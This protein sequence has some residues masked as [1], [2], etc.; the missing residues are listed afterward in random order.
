MMTIRFVCIIL[1]IISESCQQETCSKD[2][3]DCTENNKDKFQESM[4]LR[5]YFP[6]LQDI[7][8]GEY[9]FPADFFT[10]YCE[11][12]D[13]KRGDVGLSYNYMAGDKFVKRL[14]SGNTAKELNKL[15][16]CV[17]DKQVRG[18]F[19][20]GISNMPD[21]SEP[22]E[23]MTEKEAQKRICS[24]LSSSLTKLLKILQPTCDQKGFHTMVKLVTD[25][26]KNPE[27]HDI[28]LLNIPGTCI[29]GLQK[30]LNKQ[31]ND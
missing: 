8:N 27:D 4:N 14:C 3:T 17:N 10:G 7:I 22:P 9:Q 12:M 11:I 23:D 20:R 30:Q 26:L 2:G 19:V 6:E 25:I 5:R 13:N 15:V 31:F 24:F 28:P 1:S 16:P 21:I 18:S 29:T